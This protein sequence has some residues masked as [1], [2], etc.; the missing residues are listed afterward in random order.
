MSDDDGQAAHQLQLE[1]E[2]LALVALMNCK[3][4]GADPDTLDALAAEL[5]LRREWQRM[6]AQ[7][8][9]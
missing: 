2:E 1:R 8:Q 4:A 7:T 3:R 9:P 5:G 6:A